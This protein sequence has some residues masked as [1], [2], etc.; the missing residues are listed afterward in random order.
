MTYENDFVNEEIIEF[1]IEGRKFGYKPVTAGEESEWVDEY[2]ETDKDGKNKQN[3]KKLTQC[4]V[5]NLVKVPYTQE[6]IKKILNLDKEWKDLN[7][8][9]RWNLL[10]KLKP[11]VFTKIIQRINKID[12]SDPE[13]KKN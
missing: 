3:F 4:K 11:A 6:N 7:K 1:E 10:S 2:M 5:R 9:Q 8:D 12:N 13:V